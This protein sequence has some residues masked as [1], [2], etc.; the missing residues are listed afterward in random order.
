MKIFSG[1]ASR[2]LS[3]GI[4]GW[5]DMKLSAR[6]HHVFPDGEQRIQISESVLDEDTVIVQSTGM[7]VDRNYM[8]LFFTIDALKRSGARS[9]TAV[10]PYL[11]YQRQDHVF[12]EGEARSLEVV[13]S[14]LE[15]A[16]ADQFVALDLHSVKI[17]ELFTKPITHLSAL[18]L[19]AKVIKENG[20]LTDKDFLVSPDMGGIRRIGKLSV[21]L[22]EM[23]YVAIEKNRDTTSGNIQAD[24]LHG[25]VKKR[26]LIVDD[27]I[28]SGKTIAL[29][30][31]MLSEKGVE[32]IYVFATHA[33][34]SDEAP[35]ILQKSKATKVF[36]TDT[37]YI[38]E[39]KRF[40]KLEILSVA[41]LI[42]GELKNT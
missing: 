13:I 20:F 12:R 9:V 10:V 34:F 17:A 26:A 28:S 35:E 33:V 7:P 19:F 15:E 29:A 1:S 42:A 18:P 31:D 4:A 6:E 24:T 25:E 40:E 11:G 21:M 30:C 8:E 41:D 37:L 38:P 23:P 2:D 3:L 5:M 39:E 16:G 36:L 32:D 14:F 22:S 27:M